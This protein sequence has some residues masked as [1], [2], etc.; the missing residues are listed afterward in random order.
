MRRQ[1]F[2]LLCFKL[3]VF[4]GNIGPDSKTPPSK[5][6]P[7]SVIVFPQEPRVINRQ[8]CDLVRLEYR[9]I[10]VLLLECLYQ[11]IHHISQ[12]CSRNNLGL[13]LHCF[14]HPIFATGLNQI[15]ETCIRIS[16]RAV[17]T[18]SNKT[19]HGKLVDLAEYLTITLFALPATADVIQQCSM[20]EW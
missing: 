12:T 13:T 16:T 6:I 10:D 14:C 19:L 11:V 17:T 5:P 15:Q 4:P 9:H 8:S 2:L 18:V 7:R 1:V 3:D 20:V